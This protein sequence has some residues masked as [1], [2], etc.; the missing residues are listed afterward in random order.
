MPEISIT[1]FCHDFH[2]LRIFLKFAAFLESLAH[3]QFVK[4]VG[5]EHTV[6]KTSPRV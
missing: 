4:A 3:C 2:C 5:S 1:I 6:S